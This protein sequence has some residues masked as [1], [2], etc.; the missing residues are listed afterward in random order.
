MQAMR[1][2]RLA[3]GPHAARLYLDGRRVTAGAFENAH[4]GRI[5][6]TYVSRM[7]T[8]KDGSVIVREYHCIRRPR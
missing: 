2:Y 1:V 5:T 4:F 6:D 7:G 3:D 8:R